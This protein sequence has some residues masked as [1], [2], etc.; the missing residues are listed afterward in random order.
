MLLGESLHRTVGM[1]AAPMGRRS[2]YWGRHCE[3]LCSLRV[4]S[5]GED[6]IHLDV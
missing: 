4:D 3:A 1:M 5:Q 6:L 2:P